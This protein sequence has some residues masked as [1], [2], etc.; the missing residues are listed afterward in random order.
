V[1]IG[2]V[3]LGL[4]LAIDLLAARFT[5]QIQSALTVPVQIKFAAP[6]HGAVPTPA[7]TRLAVAP[8]QVPSAVPSP[9]NS[10]T[11]PPTGILAQDNFQRPDQAFWGITTGGQ[12]W[13]ADA[14]ASQSFAVVHHTGA[15]T[16]GSGVY[17]AILGPRTT[18]VEV[19]LSGSLNHY[20]T[21]SL[22][23]VLRWTDANNLYKVFLGGGQLILLKKVAG[24][25]TILKTVTFPAQDGTAYTFRFRAT[26]SQ[27]SARVWPANQPEP[28]NWMIMVTDND[29][30]SGYGGLRVVMQSGATANITSF[31]ETSL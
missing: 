2:L 24:V 15:V 19:V 9:K 26:G 4:I 12:A 10:L 21:S 18:N 20:A 14:R 28:S 5:T 23:P 13:G 16:N 1:R 3:I 27:L 7:S 11:L 22:G 31:M 29:L 30:Q 6:T 8:T 17:D 25:V